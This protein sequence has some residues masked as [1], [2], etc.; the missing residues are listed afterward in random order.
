M[1]S[2]IATNIFLT[3]FLRVSL[4]S[5]WNMI[6]VFQI[7]IFLSSLISFPPNAQLLDDALDKAL[8]MES[9]QLDMYEAILPEGLEL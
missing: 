6:N 5:M 9:L 3:I 1:N 2:A 8:E 7:I 4:E